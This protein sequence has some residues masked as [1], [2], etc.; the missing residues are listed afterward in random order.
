M[1]VVSNI[2]FNPFS[3]SRLPTTRDD[4]QLVAVITCHTSILVYCNFRCNSA[5]TSVFSAFIFLRAYFRRSYFQRAL[6]RVVKLYA[7]LQ[8]WYTAIL[9]VTQHLRSYFCVHIFAVHIFACIFLA[10][11]FLRAYFRR[12]YFQRVR[13]SVI[14]CH[15][16]FL[17]YCNFG[18][19]QLLRAYFGR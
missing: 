14:T 19:I 7:I 10:F 1:Q 16:S 2:C 5:S 13:G 11:I 18:L 4:S 3:M 15:T 8:F 6:G 17:V 12:S 9:G